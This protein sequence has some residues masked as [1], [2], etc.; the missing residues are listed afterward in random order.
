[1]GTLLHMRQVWSG[2]TC[3]GFL[4]PDPP[5]ASRPGKRR[6]RCGGS[7]RPV[8]RHAAAGSLAVA[9]RQR[10]ASAA[11]STA[12]RPKSARTASRLARQ[13]TGGPEAGAGDAALP[14]PVRQQ[15]L[16]AHVRR[17]RTESP[18]VHTASD[19]EGLA[20]KAAPLAAEAGQGQH[21]VGAASLQQ[22]EECATAQ[23]G[24]PE[25]AAG[26]RF[27]AEEAPAGVGT[28]QGLPCKA[29]SSGVIVP[30]RA[31]SEEQQ[32][33]PLASCNRQLSSVARQ[34]PAAA[35]KRKALAAGE[36]PGQATACT[37]PQAADESQ[38]TG[39]TSG[40]IA[41]SSGRPLKTISRCDCTR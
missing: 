28:P 24:V 16:A 25:T 41:L 39:P 13:T 27:G 4:T 38:A 37:S 26:R 21:T 36:E 3:A 34:R 7:V 19:V 32:R 18:T 33:H 22:A 10:P 14:L 17:A 29:A 11:P 20:S 30:I 5:A 40:Y 23:H 35:A 15:A 1:M 8:R 31:A 12:L 6:Q 9:Q 2:C